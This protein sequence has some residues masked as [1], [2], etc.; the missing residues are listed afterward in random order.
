[1]DERNFDSGNSEQDSSQTM[2]E[3]LRADKQRAAR[4]KKL[5]GASGGPLL[6]WLREERLRRGETPEQ[7]CTKLGTTPAY[8]RELWQ[9]PEKVKDISAD[10]ARSCGAYFGVP[11]IV[12]K[13][14]AG[15]VTL[16]D[17]VCSSDAED[18]AIDRVQQVLLT[19]PLALETDATWALDR[20]YERFSDTGL[21]GL[22]WLPGILE[23]LEP[24]VQVHFGHA[25]EARLMAISYGQPADK[26][27]GQASEKD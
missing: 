4:V 14:L 17:F 15:Q 19:K 22:R 10:F 26:V 12:V 2:F 7:F 13:V 21:F 18:E 11:P 1:M 5:Y 20:M 23:W 16:A 25:T 3:T 27:A 9:T 6:G 24:A 8:L